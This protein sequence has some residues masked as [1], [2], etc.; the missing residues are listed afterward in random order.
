M[1]EDGAKAITAVEAIIS[2]APQ[3]LAEL[4]AQ[5]MPRKYQAIGG[6]VV[7]ETATKVLELL[8]DITAS[9]GASF[10][11]QGIVM[12]QIKQQLEELNAKIDCLSYA[13]P[14]D[15]NGLHKKGNCEFGGGTHF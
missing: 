6:H 2:A 9:S 14:E 3:S 5:L 10:S 11:A 8:F 13:P 1:A 15:G 7:Y 4:G 12:A